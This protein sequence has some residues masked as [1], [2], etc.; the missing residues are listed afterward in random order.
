MNL[1]LQQIIWYWSGRIHLLIT[2]CHS[3]S[4]QFFRDDNTV[5]QWYYKKE[6]IKVSPRMTWID[7]LSHGDCSSRQDVLIYGLK[8]LFV[9]MCSPCATGKKLVTWWFSEWAQ[10][11]LDKIAGMS[12]E[13]ISDE[14]KQMAMQT[15]NACYIQQVFQKMKKVFGVFY[16]SRCKGVSQIRKKIS[17]LVTQYVHYM[18]N[19]QASTWFLFE[20]NNLQWS[21]NF[22]CECI[23]CTL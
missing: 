11:P 21:L 13:Q 3:Y 23:F 6:W 19:I 14:I 5:F 17:F 10:L 7:G 18:A 15:K 12:I 2:W 8:I 9:L 20:F 1:Q 4:D 16:S 22:V